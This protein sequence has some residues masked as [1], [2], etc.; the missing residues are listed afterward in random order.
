M[1]WWYRECKKCKNLMPYL[2]YFLSK[3]ENLLLSEEDKKLCHKCYVKNKNMKSL[4][5]RIIIFAIIFWVAFIVSQILLMLPVS[6]YD[7]NDNNIQLTILDNGNWIIV[8]DG[9]EYNMDWIDGRLRTAGLDGICYWY[10]GEIT[11]CSLQEYSQY[12]TK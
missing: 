5:K 4:Y 2:T 11:Q 12:L 7:Y 3:E 1:T 8:L 6:A 9:M 10:D